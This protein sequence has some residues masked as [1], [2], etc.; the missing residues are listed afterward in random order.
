MFEY[1]TEIFGAKK[2]EKRV[3]EKQKKNLQKFTKNLLTSSIQ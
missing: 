2:Y 1:P 3:Q